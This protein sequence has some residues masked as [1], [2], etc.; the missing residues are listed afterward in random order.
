MTEIRSSILHAT[1]TEKLRGHLAM[2]CFAGL[3]AGSFTLA[4]LALLHID[5]V[6]LNVVRYIVAVAVMAGWMFGIQRKRFAW[7]GAP[8]RYLVLGGLMAIYF[9]T[10]FIA[11]TMTSPVSTSAVFTLTP[12]MTVGF[13]L[14]LAGQTFG[15]ILLLSLAV[16]ASGSVWMIF[17]G[18]I[19]TLLDFRI[20]QG[21]I[22]FFFGCAA[23]A[24]YAP[25][26]RRLVRDDPQAQIG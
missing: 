17:G 18:S 4:P 21:E 7:P 24:L 22:I 3:I 19:E 20:G 5:S 11:L 13:G 23:H 8:W 10:M 26:L 1:G 15:P 6:S 16:A 2:V 25:L 14:L 12:L 9:V